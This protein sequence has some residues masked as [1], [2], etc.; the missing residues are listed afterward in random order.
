[1]E[2]RVILTSKTQNRIR[3]NGGYRDF[4]LVAD[5]T[6]GNCFVFNHDRT[7]FKSSLRAGPQYGMDLET[8]R[9]L[10]TTA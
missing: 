10:K 3:V 5:P 7:I 2:S 8:L 9:A 1:M 6:F 4:E